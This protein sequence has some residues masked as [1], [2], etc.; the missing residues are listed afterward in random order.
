MLGRIVEFVRGQGSA[1]GIQ[2]AHAGRKASTK[3]PWSGAGLI[4]PEEGGWQAVGPS[5]EAFADDYPVPRAL[6]AAG[7]AAV[8]ESF[9]DAARRARQAGF[10]VVEVH[11][12]HGYLIHEFLSPLVNHRTDAYGGSFDHRIRLCLEVVGRRPRQSGRS[13]CRSSSGC[14]APTGSR[15]AG[16][17]SSRS[18][19][20]A[21]CENA[22]SI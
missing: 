10:D 22:A 17:S 13:A 11:A 3:R 5:D 12:A 9:R 16:I 1:A 14:P 6:D 21:A 19:S 8:V 7:I 20:L 18:S 15:A 4:T 2:L